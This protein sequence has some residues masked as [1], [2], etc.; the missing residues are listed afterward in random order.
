MQLARRRIMMGKDYAVV[1][2][3]THTIAQGD[4]QKPS[5][6]RLEPLEDSRYLLTLD[7][8]S[9]AENGG[10]YVPHVGDYEYTKLCGNESNFV[11]DT[12]ELATFL[13]ES[14]HP[15]IYDGD[16]YW[17]GELHSMLNDS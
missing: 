11:V 2:D 10:F 16:L 9:T 4:D 7:S 12:D 3:G 5:T 15:V 6:V 17:S 1:G 14:E 13:A 8:Y